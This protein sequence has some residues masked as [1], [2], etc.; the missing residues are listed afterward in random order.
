[1][2]KKT[3]VLSFGFVSLILAAGLTI[4]F[5]AYQFLWTGMGTDSTEILFD[6]SPGANLTQIV[7]DLQDKGFVRNANLFLLYAR[8]RKMNSKLKV[9]EYALNKTMNADQIL[10]TLASGKSVT[11]NFTV[12]EGLTIFDIAEIFEKSGY[13]TKEEFF[14]LV[15][16]KEFI[17]SLLGEDLESLEGY[18]FPE[19]Y[20]ITKFETMKSIVSQMVKRFLVIWTK[21]DD[22]AK[23]QKWTRNQVMTFASI[24]EK[25]TGAPT[26]RP[27]VSSV[28]HNRL[29]QKIKLQ[30]D[31]TVLYGLAM[32]K[33]QM[34]NNITKADLTTPTRYNSYT[35]FGLPPTPISNPGEDSIKATLT[36]PVTK[37]LFFV[38]RNDGTTVFSE[39][40]AAHNAAVKA[41]QLNPKARDGKSWRDLKNQ[42]SA[43]QPAVVQP[44]QK[45]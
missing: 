24:V 14:K 40:Y 1:M 19:T 13:G 44:V 8:L 21:Y 20:K 31:P 10:S 32:L 35:N 26:D 2:T 17:R 38:S 11:R 28:F 23:Q 12:A 22:L 6:V 4:S 33:G 42:T 27:L 43:A 3:K 15:R 7:T 5:F 16:D 37:Y 36:P 29:T 18:L 39:S 34:P 9:G 25:E 30:T 45:K 41:Y